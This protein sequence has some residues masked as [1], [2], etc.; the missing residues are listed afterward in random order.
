MTPGSA[1]RFR[2]NSLHW[3]EIMIE[4]IEGLS[5]NLSKGRGMPRFEQDVPFVLR[6]SAE[7][8]EEGLLASF[9][10]NLKVVAAIQH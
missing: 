9:E 10:R 5:E 4:P 2:E 8:M 1:L 3:S 7:E 6:W